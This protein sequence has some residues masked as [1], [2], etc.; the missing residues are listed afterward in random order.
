MFMANGDKDP[1]H[2][3]N[4]YLL[5]I[6]TLYCFSPG[7]RGAFCV[8]WS[9]SHVGHL[10]TSTWAATVQPAV[11]GRVGQCPTVV[12]HVLLFFRTGWMW[13]FTGKIAWSMR[14]NRHMIIVDLMCDL[15]YP[16]CA[17]AIGELWFLWV[18]VFF[19]P[20]LCQVV[21]SLGWL[22][23]VFLDLV[24]CF[25]PPLFLCPFAGFTLGSGAF[26][27]DQGTVKRKAD[28]VQWAAKAAGVV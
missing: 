9:C 13:D 8:R 12:W 17:Y 22:S 1:A 15:E 27:A 6:Y 7:R 5:H 4:C 14:M 23:Y 2:V 19:F 26:V 28:L 10:V 21:L 24:C 25:L 20:G 16:H 18:H 11:V 3:H